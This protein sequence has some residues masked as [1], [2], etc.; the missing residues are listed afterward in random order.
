MLLYSLVFSWVL[1][2]NFH[3]IEVP[4]YF[5]RSLLGRSR[6]HQNEVRGPSG[7]FPGLRQFRRGPCTSSFL[8]GLGHIRPR[9]AVFLVSSFLVGLGHIRPRSAVLRSLPGLRQFRRGP[10]FFVVLLPFLVGLDHIGPRSAVSLVFSVSVTSD[11]GPRSFRSLPGLR[12]IRRG[13]CTSSV[14]GRSRSHQTEVRG[15]LGLFLLGRSR[16]HQTEVR[17]PSGLF[18]DSVTSDEVRVLLRFLV[19]LGHI[20][21]RSA[22]SEVSF[23]TQSIRTLVRGPFIS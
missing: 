17:G 23:R 4:W 20:R 19:G 2:R 21:P 6:S 18:Q 1:V 13:P 5:F 14:P 11:R 3:N 8:V 9:S 12:H 22:V 15:L 16:S 7:L 10:S